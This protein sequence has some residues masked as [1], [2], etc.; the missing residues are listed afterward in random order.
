VRKTVWE[1]RS[2]DLQI[3]SEKLLQIFSFFQKQKPALLQKKEE[4]QS[5]LSSFKVNRILLQITT[6]TA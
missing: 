4:R 3:E 2:V 6:G 5:S 1:S